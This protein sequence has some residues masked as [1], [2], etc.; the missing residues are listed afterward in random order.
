MQKP[1]P[2]YQSA[3]YQFEVTVNH[4]EKIETREHRA[5]SVDLIIEIQ[6]FLYREARLLDGEP[7]EDP[8][9]FSRRI[10]RLIERGLG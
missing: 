7:P 2:T 4:A 5:V 9:D 6:Q 10:A 8:V 1:G 3:K